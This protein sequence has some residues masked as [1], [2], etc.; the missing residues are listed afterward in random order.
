MMAM[1]DMILA[2]ARHRLTGADERPAGQLFTIL[3][4]HR[5]ATPP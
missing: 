2:A 3:S 5:T 4:F 1:G